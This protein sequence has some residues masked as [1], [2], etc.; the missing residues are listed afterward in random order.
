MSEVATLP[1]PHA[2][3]SL[4]SVL[5]DS[6]LPASWMQPRHAKD[7]IASPPPLLP[8]P[9]AHPPLLRRLVAPWHWWHG[10][11][12]YGRQIGGRRQFHGC[13]GSMSLFLHPATGV[14]YW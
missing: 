1:S 2:A 9:P 13:S 12:P 4:N 14:P 10:R 3:T 11:R 6:L 7:A 8:L 5:T